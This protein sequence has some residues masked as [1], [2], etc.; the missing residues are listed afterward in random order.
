MLLKFVFYL[1]QINIV[2]CLADTRIVTVAI[3]HI[4][5]GSTQA[6]VHNCWETQRFRSCDHHHEL[7]IRG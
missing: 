1:I 5:Q 7:L 2:V 3:I 4:S 6:A